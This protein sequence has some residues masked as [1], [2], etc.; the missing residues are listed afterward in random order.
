VPH[1]ATLPPLATL[2]PE[3]PAELDVAIHRAVAVEPA[4]RFE[5]VV[6]LLAAVD[7]A[8][9]RPADVA[10]PIERIAAR[11]PYKG[12]HAFQEADS[13]DFFGRTAIV[14][15][16]GEALAEHRL[17]AAVGPSGVG[18]S[19]IVRAGLV[20]RLRSVPDGWLVTDMLPGAFPF[21]ELVAALMR[22]AVHQPER[23]AD[24]LASGT[25]TL[26]DAAAQITPDRVLLVIDQFEELF[27]LTADDDVRSRFIANLT[28]A[29]TDQRSTVAV[30]ITLRADFLDRPLRYPELGELLSAATVMVAAPGHDE[31]VEA[32]A[33]PAAN[34]GVRFEPGLVERITAD[35]AEQPGGLPLLQYA[36]TEMFERRDTDVVTAADY[37]RSGGVLG[38]LG[39]R[40]DA[41]YGELDAAGREAT[42]QVFLR[43][44]TVSATAQD[45][46]RRVTRRE[47]RSL[48]LEP[49]AVEVV[50]DR[51][52]QRRLLTFDRHPVTRAPTVEVA[53]EA[54]LT[55]WDRLHGWIDDR[56]EEL[57]LHRRLAESVDEWE[58]SGEDADYLLSGGRLAQFE[59]LGHSDV[60]LSAS[61]RDFL[62][63]SRNAA[64]R[65]A[66]RRRRIRRTV[67]GGLVVALVLMTALAGVALRNQRRADDQADVARARELA[68]AAVAA[69]DDDPSLS[70]LLAVTSASFGELTT[71]SITALHQAWAADPVVNRLPAAPRPLNGEYVS[72]DPSGTRA[73]VGAGSQF[74]NLT[75]S[76]NYLE[77][78]DPRTEEVQWTFEPAQ[79]S[80][81]PFRP[82][83]TADGNEVVT[84]VIWVQKAFEASE[85]PAQS[86]GAFFLDA[87]TGEI[88]DHI[89][90]GR[91]GGIVDGLSDT[92]LLVKTLRGESAQTCDWLSGPVTVELVGRIDGGR[93]VLTS[94]GASSSN[95][96]ALSADGRFV[97]F[98]DFDTG[99]A[100]VIDLAT[101]E[102]LLDFR[103]TAGL[104]SAINQDGSLL[105][106]G[107]PIEIRDVTTG[108]VVSTYAGHV[109]ASY[110]AT[111]DSSGSG[112]YSVGEDNKLHHWDA[113]TGLPIAVFPEIG[114]QHISAT[115]DGVVLV[116]R[117]DATTSVVDTRVRGEVGAIE[118][119]PGP[120][121]P[122]SL[123]VS[124][125][126][127]VLGV[128]CDGDP[129]ATTYVADLQTGKVAYV[130]PG[131]GG[132]GLSISP[133]GTRFARQEA[134]GT[135]W[136]ALSIRDLATGRLLVE[137]DGL[138]EWE[139][140]SS[141]PWDEREGCQPYPRT[142]FV[143]AAQRLH[144]SPDGTMLA[145]GGA[146][147]I[148]WDTATGKMLHA[149][150]APETKYSVS[151]EDEGNFAFDVVFTPDSSRLI[152][153]GNIEVR[154]IRTD[155]WELEQ[156]S[157]LNS[158]QFYIAFFGFTSDGSMLLGQGG[159]TGNPGATMEWIDAGSLAWLREVSPIHDAGVVIRAMSPDQSLV[160][161][162]G[163]DGLVRVW[164]AVSGVLVNEIPFGEARIGGVDFV[165]GRHLAVAFDDGSVR[166]VT[167]DSAELLDIV[168]HSLERGFTESECDR[169][170]L[171]DDCPTLFELR[172]QPAGADDPTAINGTYRLEWTPDDLVTGTIDA[173]RGFNLS[174]EG[175]E[176]AWSGAQGIAFPG[177]HTLRFRD[178][179]WDHT[180]VDA[181]GVRRE[182]TGSYAIRASRI[183]LRSERGACVIA[184][185]FDAGFELSGGQLRFTGYD[186]F[187]LELVI[188]TMK[189][190]QRTS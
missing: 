112:V 15:E 107:D 61:E 180:V 97:A 77:A 33:R 156:Q 109:G 20:P 98:D 176:G 152:V 159:A 1:D 181:D 147:A 116:G 80:A 122:D 60:A 132:E 102:T 75:S 100:S 163:A 99:R 49:A 142:P 59:P 168:R 19:S 57:L 131:Q 65:R 113:L 66:V 27:T 118:T 63:A 108:E 150:V 2:R 92:H 94:N 120:V 83:F 171:G 29:A 178:G 96:A 71:E 10:E 167:I 22:V 5:S 88:V 76:W 37:E 123:E 157:P 25:T 36:L 73:V 148:V 138:C 160:A 182:C 79:V 18:K 110:Y 145:T 95:G 11:N 173:Y 179:R 187:P 135:T 68:A 46:R 130:L 164:D 38:A 84:G 133:D 35:V 17:I 39:R 21:D 190:W 186:G 139:S 134:D 54:M 14:D 119:C 56:R 188:Y 6:E 48:P 166:L 121:L 125:G 24:D 47:L 58:R 129:S 149:E 26:V 101:G 105:A 55:R 146:G 91:C 13:S 9:A 34:V 117:S 151:D 140:D 143:L 185:M 50:L 126:M 51:F 141:E 127:A 3:L 183:E 52:G 177:S 86:V 169:F 170:D 124:G 153:S 136:G 81:A 45:T 128:Q 104:V 87:E 40:A 82:F 53:H 172:G 8:F 162:G 158:Q 64:E 43:L 175:V 85:P 184:R 72:I 161:T 67:V 165:D 44:V 12:L 106:D 144:W 32:I 189:P 154:S 70:K 23:L 115:A 111:F 74:T 41:L 93:R 28:D 7:A 89:D 42:R 62:V 16:L 103:S 30:L 69:V 137:L 78:I 174:R 4:D 155:T 90:L 31:L 114:Q